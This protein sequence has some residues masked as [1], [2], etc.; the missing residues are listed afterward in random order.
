MDLFILGI[1]PP[2]YPLQA[3]AARAYDKATLMFKGVDKAR[4][5]LNFPLEDYLEG[6]AGGPWENAGIRERVD[7]CLER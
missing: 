2:P 3:E 4:A 1:D 6:G 7:A 5:L